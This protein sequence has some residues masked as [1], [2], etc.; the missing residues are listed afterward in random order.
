[1]QTAAVTLPRYLEISQTARDEALTES[2]QHSGTAAVER[3]PPDESAPKAAGLQRQRYQRGAEIFR[4]GQPGEFAYLIEHGEVE[5]S[6]IRRGRRTIIATLGP[7]DLF[8]EMA[9]LDRRTRSAT[10]TAVAETEVVAIGRD[11]LQ[12]RIKQTDPV[13][14]LLLKVILHRFRSTLWRMLE[15]ENMAPA[16]F[17]SSGGL[18]AIGDETREL[19]IAQIKV[20]KAMGVQDKQ[21]GFGTDTER[22]LEAD[23]VFCKERSALPF[24][25]CRR[26]FH[27]DNREVASG[28]I[29]HPVNGTSNRSNSRRM[30]QTPTRAP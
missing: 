21:L 24:H 1:M 18:Q 19:A 6:A 3:S 16:A 11:Q 29:I 2:T 14:E 17:S 12:Q 20:A 15:S 5:V 22:R 28:G 4:E 23:A 13:L 27:R 9:L 30:R 25:C 7:G 26:Q 10:A 8:G